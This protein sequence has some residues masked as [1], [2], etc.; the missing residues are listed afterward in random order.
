MKKFLTV[1]LLAIPVLG[2]AQQQV[3]SPEEQEKKIYEAIQKEVDRLEA[4]LELEGW[5]IFYTDSILTNNYYAMYAEL[6]NLSDNKVSNSDIYLDVQ[7]K[8][9]EK[10]YQALLKILN[11][12]QCTKYNKQGAAAAKKARDKRAASKTKQK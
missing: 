11:P 2:F 3:E 10:T 1:F 7:D 5:Q 9:Y 6:K 4:V 12:E 8:W